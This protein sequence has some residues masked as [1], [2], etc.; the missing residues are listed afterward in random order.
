MNISSRMEKAHRGMLYK[1]PTLCV[2]V[3]CITGED[4]AARLRTLTLFKD[5]VLVV[6]CFCLR[7]ETTESFTCTL[8][9]VHMRN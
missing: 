6:V 2:Q 9:L 7:H 3:V 4:G 8:S 1:Q 5:G